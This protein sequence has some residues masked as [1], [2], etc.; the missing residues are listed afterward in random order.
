MSVS[1]VRELHPESSLFKNIDVGGWG[2][3]CITGKGFPRS[4]C[5][6]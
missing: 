3:F 5:G 1:P 6:T 2:V 4:T